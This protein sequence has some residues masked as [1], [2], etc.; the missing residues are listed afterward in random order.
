MELYQAKKEAGSGPAPSDYI[1]FA[2]L[3][4]LCFL[5]MAMGVLHLLLIAGANRESNMLTAKTFPSP[6]GKFTEWIFRES[7][8]GL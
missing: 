5:R 8:P 2:A 1:F 4:F 3:R 6:A 7:L